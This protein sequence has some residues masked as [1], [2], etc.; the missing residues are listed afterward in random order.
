MLQS[1]IQNNTY[2]LQLFREAMEKE[3]YEAIHNLAHK[4]I[5]SFRYLEMRNMESKLR[6]LETLTKDKEHPEAI[7]KLVDEIIH[8]TEGLF[9]LLSHE[10]EIIHKENPVLTPT[11]TTPIE[12]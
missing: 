1:F 2:H 12:S 11:S 3:D 10:I 7:S 8:E 9:P 6:Q 5:P 4:M